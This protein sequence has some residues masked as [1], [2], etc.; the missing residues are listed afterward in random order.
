MTRV[1]PFPGTDQDIE[2]IASRLRESLL[3]GTTKSTASF[4]RDLL[5]R[6]GGE[7]YVSPDPGQQE[8]EGGSLVIRGERDYTIYLSPYTTTHSDN[9]MIAHEVGHY[10]LHFFPRKEELA[11]PL[12][13]PRY[14]VGPVEWQANRFAAALLMPADQF[15]AKYREFDGRLPLL[16]GSFSVSQDSVEVRARSLGLLTP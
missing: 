8:A 14:G 1:E 6:T 15:Q 2:R 16:S 12:W 9:F 11:V 5:A 13:F 3:D 7:T 10:V 4:V